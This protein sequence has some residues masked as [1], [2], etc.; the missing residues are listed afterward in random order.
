MFVSG[1]VAALVTRDN[2]FVFGGGSNAHGGTEIT[3][4]APLVPTPFRDTKTGVFK[5]A[6]YIGQYAFGIEQGEV[7]F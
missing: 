3:I 1:Y 4:K 6:V 5:G 2:Y 7:C